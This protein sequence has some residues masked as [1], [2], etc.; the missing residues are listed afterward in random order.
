MNGVILEFVKETPVEKGKPVKD[1][2]R[3]GPRSYAK[4]VLILGF[5][6][7][8][9][10]IAVGCNQPYSAPPGS[11]ST[12]I[13]PTS[14]FATPIGQ[15]P[16]IS[17]SDIANF[18]TQT[19]VAQTGIPAN[20]A[21]QTL[22]P[23]VTLPSFPWPPPKPSATALL[24][25]GS[26]GQLAGTGITFHDVDTRISGALDAAGYDEKAYFGVPGGFAIVTRLEKMDSYG[27]PDH[28][29]RWVSSLA[30]ISPTEFSL[31]KYLEALFGAPMGHYRVLVFIVTS[32][33]IVPSGTAVA[34]SEA[35]TWIVE[36][37][38]RLPSSMETL[39]YTSGYTTT[40]YIYEFVQSGVGGT[41]NQNIPSLY[42]GREHLQ[43]T[44]LWQNL[45][46]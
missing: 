6:S 18:G 11:T 28:A 27:F 3:K 7:I 29:N 9:L 2:S 14:L 25:L 38:N 44:G 24:T 26:V 40:V 37:A 45:E 36:G 46:Q 21:T 32:E 41:A 12:P 8:L 42:T 23:G 1:S 20:I 17:M 15:T 22:G 13:N 34:Q 39:Q 19:A 16:A 5:I 35:Q 10:I 31:T 33:T 4:V 43:E 30:P